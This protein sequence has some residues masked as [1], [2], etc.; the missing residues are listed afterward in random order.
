[1]DKLQ[2][3]IEWME[4][5]ILEEAKRR[6]HSVGHEYGIYTE[7]QRIACVDGFIERNKWVI[8][9]LST[10]AKELAAQPTGQ[11]T[12]H[13]VPELPVPPE[14]L[15]V[16]KYPPPKPF[17]WM[18]NY[19]EGDITYTAKTTPTDPL[20]A[21]DKMPPLTTKT[22]DNDGDI[23]QVKWAVVGDGQVFDNIELAE[24]LKHYEST[25][26]NKCTIVKIIEP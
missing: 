22:G 25:F 5:E 7:E 16:H 3:L 8:S 10:K 23:Q 1:M 6:C 14:D 21:A 13:Q 17:G 19:T 4:C 15:T 2:Q 11:V 20:F 9:A 12:D 24:K 26:G 18:P